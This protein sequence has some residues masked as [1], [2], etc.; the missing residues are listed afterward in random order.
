MY[1]STGRGR[2][3]AVLLAAGLSACTLLLS[4]CG[5]SD[6]KPNGVAKA[7]GAP[8][9]LRKK[10]DGGGPKLSDK[11]IYDGLL[12]YSKCMRAH[13]VSKFPDPVL[14]K[15]LQVNGNQVGSNTPTYK[16]ADAK[17]KSLVP[18]GG[19]GADNAPK[20]RAA[21]LK[22]SKCMR[23]H[24]VPK[25]PDPNPNGGLNLDGDKIGMA[26][27]SPTFK[28]ALKACQPLLGSGYSQSG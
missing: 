25:F 12:K 10:G 24:G 19:P 22:Y 1:R 6:D 17:C 2:S 9:Q 11:Q 15:G 16:A 26:P 27:D 18:G 5:G 4:G 23:S 3:A 28:A 14:G 13:G 21:A 7:P 8:S 20:D